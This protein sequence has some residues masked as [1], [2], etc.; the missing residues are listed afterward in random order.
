MSIIRCDGKPFTDP[1]CSTLKKYLEPR[2][3]NVV[4]FPD[5][6]L[7]VIFSAVFTWKFGWDKQGLD[8]LG[9]VKG[10]GGHTFAFRWPF[11]WEQL[12]H[13]RTAMS[14]SFI[15]SLLGF[16]ESSIAAKGLRSA[17]QDGIDGMTYS[18]N[19]ELVALGA[20]NI[21]GGCFMA[22]PSFGG[23]G[24]SKLSAATGGKTPMSSMFLSLITVVCIVYLL[25]Y[26]YYLP[27]S[28]SVVTD[29]TFYF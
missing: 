29:A 24:R 1:F 10:V 17:P 4:F 14:T 18:P 16:F 19:R 28:Y 27:V 13:I 6:L 25:P 26:F 15:I 22:L 11:H 5:Q 20:A 2:F 12:D 7:V 8:I 9:D 3:P 21:L 23:Y